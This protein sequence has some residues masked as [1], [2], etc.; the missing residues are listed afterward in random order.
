MARQQVIAQMKG[1]AAA[2]KEQIRQARLKRRNLDDL[3]FKMQDLLLTRRTA[4]KDA[5]AK[6]AEKDSV[7]E[8]R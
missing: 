1:Q 3:E 4:L 5:L 7:K 2:V 8:G 6:G